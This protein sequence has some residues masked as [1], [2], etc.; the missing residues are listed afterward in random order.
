MIEPNALVYVI[1]DDAL[2]RCGLASLLKSVG[3]SAL[4]FGSAQDFIDAKR[5]DV[6]SCLVLDVRLPGLSGLDLQRQL[7]SMRMHIPIIF[8]TG[9]GDIPMSVRAMKEGAFEFLTK[10]VRGQE[11]LDAVQRALARDRELRRGHAELD[12][13]RQRFAALTARENEVLNL[14]VAGLLNKQIA[15]KLGT[16]EFTIKSHRAHLMQK[17]GANSVAHLVSMFERLNCS[18]LTITL[19]P[20]QDSLTAQI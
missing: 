4:T 7:L 18:E 13:L 17:T 20:K 1:D 8:I 10:P 5:P 2:V 12:G 19:L 14:I 6:S 3:L 11:I 15:D 9:H 16:S